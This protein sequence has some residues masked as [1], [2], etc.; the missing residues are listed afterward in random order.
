MEFQF[1]SFADFLAMDGHGIFVWISYAVTFAALAAMALYPR[2]ARRR[3]QRELQ[4]QQRISQRR[5]KVKAARQ[6]VKEPA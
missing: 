4:H 6:A 2:L 1:S 3:L 5:Q